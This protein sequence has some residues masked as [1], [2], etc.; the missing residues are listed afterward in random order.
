MQKSSYDFSSALRRAVET[1]VVKKPVVR[2]KQKPVKD[3]IYGAIEPKKNVQK[4]VLPKKNLTDAELQPIWNKNQ[5]QMK[6][7]TATAL[8]SMQSSPSP[9][10]LPPI[11]AVPYG[12]PQMQVQGILS[13]APQAQSTPMWRIK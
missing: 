10:P 7:R 1:S 4:K 12:R 2:K 9:Q 13:T 3:A 6:S 5:A 11:P 8:A